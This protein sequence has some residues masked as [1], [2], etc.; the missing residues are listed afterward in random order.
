[1]GYVTFPLPYTIAA[2]PDGR[3]D[4]GGTARQS[5][6]IQTVTRPGPSVSNRREKGAKIFG[7]SETISLLEL[8]DLRRR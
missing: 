8:D 5:E 7:K 2:L 1:M 4:F 6:T 3:P